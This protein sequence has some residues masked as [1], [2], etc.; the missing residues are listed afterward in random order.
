MNKQEYKQEYKQELIKLYKTLINNDDSLKDF[1]RNKLDL[2]D[3]S[4][5]KKLKKYL[6]EKGIEED[7]TIFEEYGKIFNERQNLKKSN[8]IKKDEPEEEKENES[9]TENEQEEENDNDLNTED[10]LNENELN[11]NE[12]NTDNENEDENENENENKNESE[13]ENS[14][15]Y[16]TEMED[17]KIAPYYNSGSN[18]I[19]NCDCLLG[20][21]NLIN[22]NQE[23]ELTITSP[24]YFNVKDYVNYENYKKY[25]DFLKKVFIKILK[26]TKPGRLCIVNISNI[27]IIRESRNSESKRI[28]LSFHFVSLMEQIGWQFMEDIIW[29]KPEGAAKNRNGGFYQ[30]RQPVAYKPN[31][32]NEYIFV[33]KKP[34]DFLIDKVV[35][36]Y[37]SLDALNSKVVG[38][39]ERS[40]VWKINPKTRSDHPAPYPIEL[41]DK[42]VKYYSFVGD[43]II[44]PFFGSG[45]KVL[46]CKKYNRKC[47]GFEIHENYIE[48]FKKDINTIIPNKLIENLTLDKKDFE[49]LSKEDCIKK[50]MKNPK[51][52]IFDILVN[53]TPNI[54][55]S[56]SKKILAEKLYENL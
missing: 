8:V 52:M 26:I 19:Y 37:N 10:E 4:K 38:N 28:P 39:Y 42:I 41:T 32:V 18:I 50:M 48:L 46:S 29:L 12:L 6:E 47:I 44:D 33:F 36:S 54:K 49:D 24:P 25:L 35:R 56:N 7:I 1:K 43:T 15:I 22:D 13:N 53:I 27:L 16:N 23:I 40:N 2:F 31:V 21:N 45:T 34:C 17:K 9:T 14:N 3:M 20:L 51:K 11:E 30:H 55:I 5:K